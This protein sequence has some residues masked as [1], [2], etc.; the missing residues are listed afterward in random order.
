KKMIIEQFFS[1]QNI[2]NFIKS[3][4]IKR[5]LEDNIAAKIDYNKIFDSFIDMLMSSTSCS[6]IDM[7]LGGRSALEGLREPFTKNLD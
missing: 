1:P 7:F 2:N 6:L 3:D 5:Y 4:D